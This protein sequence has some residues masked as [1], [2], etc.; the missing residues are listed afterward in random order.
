M[1]ILLKLVLEQNS[2]SFIQSCL[3]LDLG[4]V[5]TPRLRQVS[6]SKPTSDREQ[7]MNEAD[8]APWSRFCIIRV[9]I[10]CRK[11]RKDRTGRNLMYCSFGCFEFLISEIAS[12]RDFL[13]QFSFSHLHS[14]ST[15]R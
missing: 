10:V 1:K 13:E 7:G 14:K 2:V 15:P 9:R 4:I 11:L 12:D 8:C 6:V 5:P 3:S